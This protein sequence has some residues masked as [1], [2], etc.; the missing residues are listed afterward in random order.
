LV[1]A[2]PGWTVR[3]GSFAVAGAGA[4]A[5]GPVAGAASVCGDEMAVELM[6]LHGWTGSGVARYQGCNAFGEYSAVPFLSGE[7]VAGLP[8]VFVSA[9][10]LGRAVMGG[11]VAVAV[12]VTAMVPVAVAVP[13]TVAVAGECVVADWSDGRRDEFLLGELF[14]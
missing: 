6:A 13:V 5:R 2:P 3:E 11:S 14:G 12:P 1:T 10:R 7:P 9:H 8:T 4:A